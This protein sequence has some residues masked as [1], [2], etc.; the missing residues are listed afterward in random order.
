MSNRHRPILL[1]LV[2]RVAGLGLQ[3]G[4]VTLPVIAR[5]APVRRQQM[6][7]PAMI[8]VS[9]SRTPEQVSR[10]R[11]GLWQTRY[12]FDVTVVSPFGGPDA[13]GPDGDTTQYETIRDTLVDALKAKPLAGAPDVFDLDARPADWLQPFAEAGAESQWDWQSLQVLA[14]VAHS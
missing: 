7:P 8:A 12:A 2:S 13:A 3:V 10:R 4:G 6:D 14:T 5:K 11:F 1:A 9:K